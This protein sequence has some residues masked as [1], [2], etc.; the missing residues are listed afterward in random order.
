[1]TQNNP[2]LT[3]FGIHQTH[4]EEQVDVLHYLRRDMTDARRDLI[5]LWG[6]EVEAQGIA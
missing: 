3:R 2:H 5:K 1:V 4:P 6:K